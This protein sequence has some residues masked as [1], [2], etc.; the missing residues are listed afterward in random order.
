MSKTSTFT[1]IVSNIA[2]SSDLEL[3]P[4]LQRMAGRGRVQRCWHALAMPDAAFAPW[5][6]ALLRAL[7]LTPDASRLPSAAV[8]RCGAAPCSGYWLHATPVHFAAGLETLSLLPLAGDAAVT[9]QEAAQ[10]RT[11]LLDHLG[12]QGFELSEE[13]DRGWLVRAAQAL[14]LATHSPDAAARQPLEQSFPQGAAARTLRRLMTECQMLLHDH[15]VNQQ[16]ARRDLPAVNALWFWGAGTAPATADRPL[17]QVFAASPFAQGLCQLHSHV[18]GA[19]PDTASQL[20]QQPLHGDVVVVIEA[21][22]EALDSAWIAPLWQGL[23][24]GRWSN[25]EV[26]L[27]A[28]SVQASRADR[29][30]FWRRPRSLAQVQA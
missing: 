10:L 21:A 14:D 22:L 27:D 30:R 6:I 13:F 15:P 25:L 28:W 9:P 29:W 23:Q 18:C 16:R 24:R 5:Q 26:V 4:L 1:L 19:V 17:P 20:L 12:E 8:A 3:S 7:K 2:A 11:A